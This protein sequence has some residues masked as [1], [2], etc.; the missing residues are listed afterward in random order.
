MPRQVLYPHWNEPPTRIVKCKESSEAHP[1]IL[2]S[3]HVYIFFSPGILL[4]LHIFPLSS[5]II[6]S[7]LLY[8]FRHSFPYPFCLLILISS[9]FSNIFQL[10]LYYPVGVFFLL[11]FILSFCS[12]IML[13]AWLLILQ[14]H[15]GLVLLTT[16][17]APMLMYV[18]RNVDILMWRHAN[19]YTPSCVDTYNCCVDMPLW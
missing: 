8:Y 6:T 12:Y 19:V 1:C 18:A 13:A 11:L 14:L 2:S 7:F 9:H 10:L 4:H 5:F 17:P 16:C 3:L 15:A